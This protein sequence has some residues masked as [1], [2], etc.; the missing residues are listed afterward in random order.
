MVVDTGYIIVII[1]ALRASHEFRPLNAASRSATHLRGTVRIVSRRDDVIAAATDLLRE[2]GPAELTSVNVAKRLGVTQSAIYRHIRDMDELTTLATHGIVGE[3]SAVVMEAVA[4]PD[5]TWGDGTH[6]AKFANRIVELM[7]A[8]PQALAEIDRW[9][10][11]DG[12]LGEG[13]REML[14]VG[15]HLLAS[16]FEKAWR[17]DFDF[18]AAFDETIIAVQLAHSRLEVDDVVAVTRTISGAGPEQRQQMART[19]GLRLFAGWCGYVL[20]L[21]TRLGIRIPQL[22]EPTLSSPEYST[23]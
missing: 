8:H 16:E 15:A 14:D 9:R 22:G 20:D 13:I 19:L 4:S 21:N 23:T 7:E 10:Y 11:D 18:V 6:I 17:I 3:L 2:S 1:G 12:P 5:T